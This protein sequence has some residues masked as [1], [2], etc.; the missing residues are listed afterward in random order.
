MLFTSGRPETLCGAGSTLAAT[1]SIRASLVPL[2]RDLAVEVLLDAPCGDFNWMAAVDLDGIE[3]IG[4]DSSSANLVAA[5]KRSANTFRQVDIVAGLLPM[6]DAMLC[7]DFHQHMP[8]SMVFAALRNFRA[9]GIDWLLATNHD[10][11]ENEDIEQPGMFRRINLQKPPFN[12]P[13]PMTSI[14]DPDRGHVLALWHC[15]DVLA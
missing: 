14:P 2:L 12:L 8:N 4:C 10:N 11:A 5:R 13:A 3:Y 6:A 9:A 7:R 15:N 1:E